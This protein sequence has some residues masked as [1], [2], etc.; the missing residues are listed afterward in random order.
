MEQGGCEAID[1]FAG[2]LTILVVFSLYFST[3]P[4]STEMKKG[5]A[6]GLPLCL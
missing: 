3:P 5:E 6:C 4:N 1:F 2:G